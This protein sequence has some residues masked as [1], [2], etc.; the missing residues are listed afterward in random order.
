MQIN[1][2]SLYMRFIHIHTC[3]PERL[4]YVLLYACLE[5]GYCV[6]N[7]FRNVFM[8]IYL[9][10]CLKKIINPSLCVNYFLTIALW[11]IQL[12]LFMARLKFK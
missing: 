9:I 1:Y 7:A 5:F 11:A 4:F 2:A 3:L 12:E 10:L 8:Y 6:F